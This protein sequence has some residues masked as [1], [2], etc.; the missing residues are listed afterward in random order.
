MQADEQRYAF[1]MVKIMTKTTVA[2]VITVTFCPALL[3]GQ[4]KQSDSRQPAEWSFSL[5][6]GGVPWSKKF[7]VELNHAGKLSMTEQNPDKMPG[8]IT[9]KFTVD[10]SAKDAQE[11][12]EQ[13]LKAF[14]EFRFLEKPETRDGTN[15][16]LRLSAYGR[17]LVMQLFNI[18]LMDEESPEVAKVLSLINKH[19]PRDHQVY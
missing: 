11:I 17:V 9:S 1:P 13:T 14:R 10:L 5:K 12:Y 19:L 3:H 7:E 6:T 16:T 4:I 15:L 8:D 18:G 2:L